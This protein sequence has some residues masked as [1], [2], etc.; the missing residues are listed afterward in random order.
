MSGKRIQSLLGLLHGQTWFQ[1]R[2]GAWQKALGTHWR[3]K[4]RIS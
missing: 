3:R 4:Y 2:N 1:S